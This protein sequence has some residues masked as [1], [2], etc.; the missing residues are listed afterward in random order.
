MDHE[1]PLSEVSRAALHQSQVIDLTTKG[2]RSGQMRRIEIFLH[3]DD[4]RLFIT[5][6]PRA[7]SKRDWI[8]NIES[9]PSRRCSLEAVG[10]RG[11]AGDGASGH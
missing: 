7:D 3:S 9:R 10:R 2:R 6:M 5:G 11:P 4:G 8:Y 1:S